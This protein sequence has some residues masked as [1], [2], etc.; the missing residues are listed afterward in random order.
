M[1]LIHHQMLEPA[2]AYYDTYLLAIALPL[3][4]PCVLRVKECD[5]RTHR[6]KYSLI[7]VCPFLLLARRRN[8]LAAMALT[9]YACWC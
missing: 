4:D 1:W 9:T 6:Y 2:Q 8:A 5:P 3:R 7:S